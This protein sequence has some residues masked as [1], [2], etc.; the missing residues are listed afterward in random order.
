MSEFLRDFT[1]LGFA[2]FVSVAALLVVFLRN[3]LHAAVALFFCLAGIS[4][5]YV[6]LGADF[7]GVT[8]LLVYAGGILVLIIFGVLLTSRIYQVQYDLT[9]PRLP[10]LAGLLVA[11]SVFALVLFVLAQTTW[12]EQ[13]LPQAPTTRGIAELLL[14]K[15]LLPFEVVSVLLLFAMLGAVALVRKEIRDE[16]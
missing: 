16:S 4:V 3:I 14:T 8:Q 1:F 12:P 9:G 6:L 2:G 13:Q 15:Y 10:W 7:L 5:L 11:L